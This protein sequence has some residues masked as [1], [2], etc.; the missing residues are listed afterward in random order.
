V[1]SFSSLSF[2]E[3][4]LL[5][6]RAF[7]DTINLFSTL[8]VEDL[9]RRL[10]EETSLCHWTG[11]LFASLALAFS[12]L[13]CCNKASKSETALFPLSELFILDIESSS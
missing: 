5:L 2:L 7:D 1:R 13:A 9:R 8:H 12:A 11:L 10:I 4:Q 6:L 3:A